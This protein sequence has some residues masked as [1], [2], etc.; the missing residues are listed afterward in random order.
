MTCDVWQ[1]CLR[2]LLILPINLGLVPVAIQ[3]QSYESGSL[4]R[5][6]DCHGGGLLC[7]P[8]M[9]KIDIFFF[10]DKIVYIIFF[11]RFI[12]CMVFM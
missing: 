3:R 2:L 4:G 12:L 6:K 1:G 8:V 5:G 7:G 11:W 10:F 9:E